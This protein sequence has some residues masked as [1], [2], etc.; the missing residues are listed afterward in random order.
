MSK[1]N[2]VRIHSLYILKL[3][4]VLRPNFNHTLKA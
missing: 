1:Y 2:L 4:T 3:N